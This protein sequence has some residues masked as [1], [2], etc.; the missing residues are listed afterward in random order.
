MPRDK[1]AI[2][3][4][5]LR[6]GGGKRRIQ[7]FLSAS[8]LRPAQ[9]AGASQVLQRNSL[10]RGMGR[11]RKAAGDC[12]AQGQGSHDIL[13][14]RIAHQVSGP[15]RRFSET[16]WCGI[17]NGLAAKFPARTGQGNLPAATEFFLA[18]WELLARAGNFLRDHFTKLPGRNHAGERSGNEPVFA[19]GTTLD[20]PRA[21]HL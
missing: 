8:S 17:F 19:N 16:S 9:Q 10:D 1:P 18:K 7:L 21:S 3:K 15:I 2:V 12:K 20:P 4:R 11:E 5:H 14:G 13:R 6:R